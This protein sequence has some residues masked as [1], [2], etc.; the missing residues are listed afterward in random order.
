MIPEF[1]DSMLHM[2][3]TLLQETVEQTL[4]QE[5][6]PT[7][8]IYGDCG[9]TM[10]DIDKRFVCARTS[11]LNCGDL[12]LGHARYQKLQSGLAFLFL[13]EW[14]ERWRE[15]FQ[16]ELGFSNPELARI[17]M[18]DTRKSLVYVDTGLIPV[19]RSTLREIEDYFAMPVEIQ[20]ATLGPLRAKIHEGM[21]LL[22][23]IAHDHL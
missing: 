8:I 16:I 17:F 5:I 18:H 4:T 9:P 22:E 1:L 6:L 14:T 19:P 7:L 10:H 20:S 3:P 15:V 21:Q 12:L 23:R 13:P 2:H 11:S